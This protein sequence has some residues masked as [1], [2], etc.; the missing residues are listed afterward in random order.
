MELDTCGIDPEDYEV[1]PRDRQ[2]KAGRMKRVN[3][4][5]LMKWQ[6]LGFHIDMT[7]LPSLVKPGDILI[8]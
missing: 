3:G 6:K 2:N 1:C 4:G 7:S 8:P 5:W